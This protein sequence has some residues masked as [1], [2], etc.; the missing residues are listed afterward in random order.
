M[1]SG[2][3]ARVSGGGLPQPLRAASDWILRLLPGIKI[4]KILITRSG[5]DQNTSPE[6]VYERL[7]RDISN[8]RVPVAGA[9][10]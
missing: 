3:V 4:G 6:I 8:R 5:G 9:G 1:R 7:P 2:T 10:V